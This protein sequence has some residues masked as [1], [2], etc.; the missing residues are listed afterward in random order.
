MDRKE[1]EKDLKVLMFTSSQVTDSN[2]FKIS[3]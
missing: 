1:K 3:L 2:R